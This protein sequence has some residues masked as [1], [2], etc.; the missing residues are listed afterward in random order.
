MQTVISR[1]CTLYMIF[2]KTLA[3]VVELV[4]GAFPCYPFAPRV[5]RQCCC[6]L[7]G[8][9]EGGQQ[10][11]DNAAIVSCLFVLQDA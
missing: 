2:Q 7:T 3:G 10:P 8:S 5:N 6:R 9:N 4:P 1:D 11:S